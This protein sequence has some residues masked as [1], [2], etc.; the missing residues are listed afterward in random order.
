LQW[1]FQVAHPTAMSKKQRISHALRQFP[2]S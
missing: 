2:N 1:T